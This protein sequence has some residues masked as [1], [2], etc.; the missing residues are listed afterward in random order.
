ML[1]SGHLP[2]KCSTVSS[3]SPHAKHTL[4]SVNLILNRW[5][6]RP[7]YPERRRVAVLRSRS[8]PS[9]SFGLT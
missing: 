2:R 8:S 4:N 1:D 3:S 5:L 7:T 6:L 9:C